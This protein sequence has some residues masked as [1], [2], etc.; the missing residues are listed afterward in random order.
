[1][2]ISGAGPTLL[3]LADTTQSQAVEMA[4]LTAWQEAGITAVVRSLSLDT[5][6][7]SSFHE[8]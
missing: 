6:G 3:A 5:Q 2:V 7:A 8:G 4:M 1:M